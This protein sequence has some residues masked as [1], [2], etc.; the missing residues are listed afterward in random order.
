MGVREG[1]GQPQFDWSLALVD[2]RGG[3]FILQFEEI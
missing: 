3:R 2:M 1:G